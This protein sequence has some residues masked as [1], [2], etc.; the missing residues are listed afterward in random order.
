MRLKK[1]LSAALASVMILSAGSALAADT[2]DGKLF[3]AKFDFGAGKI[4]DGYTQITA[5][6]KYTEKKG[7]GLTDTEQLSN[8]GSDTPDTL[9]GDYI[10]SSDAEK[11]INF[12]VDVPDGDYQ[13]KV[14]NGGETASKANIYINEGERVRVFDIEAGKYAENT[15]PVLPKDG[16]ITI[17]V[18]GEGA[19]LNAVEITQLPARTEKGEKPTIYIAG[20]STAQTYKDTD[21]PQTGWGQVAADYFT[22]DVIVENRSMGGRST[23]SYNNDGRL[24]RILTEL[25]PGDYVFIQFGHNDGSSKPERYIS[26]DDFKTL[27]TEKYVGETI[28]RGG[29]PVLLTPTPHYSPDETT[30]QFSET[31][32]DYSNKTRE[33]AAE[34]GSALLDIHKEAVARWNELGKEKVKGFYFINEPNESAKYPEGTDDH[35]HFKE[36]GAR[37]IAKITAKSVKNNVPALAPFAYDYENP[38]KKDFSDMKNHWAQ[39]TVAAMAQA[40]L[41]NGV[42]ETEFAPEKQVTRAEFLA[43]AMRAA[44]LTGHAWRKD[45]CYTDVKE[46]DWYRFYVQSAYD[47]KCIND[48]MISNHAFVGDSAIT[49]EEMASIAV[50]V[51]N[52]VDAS[53]MEKLAGQEPSQDEA[54]TTRGIVAGMDELSAWS[55]NDMYQAVISG[56][57]NGVA[58]ADREGSSLAPKDTATRAQAATI[59]YRLYGLLEK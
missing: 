43:M 42:S 52:S 55:G 7:Y 18:K 1:I 19:K 24:D 40:E 13:V 54:Y 9:Q 30:G 27:L 32:I 38:P 35:T 11:G 33:V 34:T 31:I 39:E 53:I 46:T 37:E 45:G 12:A 44:G 47:K 59:I 5:S 17:Q 14:I 2:Q 10:T 51:C 4:A 36:A 57:V 41:V 21:Y 28:K 58:L 15:Q 23:K 6:S 49:R 22:D 8:G 50:A 25:K 26:P 20:D 3:S 56:L 48:G 29:I 16:K